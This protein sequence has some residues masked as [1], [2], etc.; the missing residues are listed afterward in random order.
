MD[1]IATW[2]GRLLAAGTVFLLGWG[3]ERAVLFIANR[4][5]RVLR[6]I[7]EGFDLNRHFG[8][9][10]TF[11]LWAFLA[12]SVLPLM[13]LPEP[14]GERASLV[15][16]AAL[17][18]SI[19][20]G[21]V[22][23]I[24][25]GKEVL[26]RRFEIT[27]EDNLAQRRVRTQLQYI[28]RVAAIATVLIG[29]AA[30]LLALPGARQF[31]ASL[32]ASAG[33]AGIVIGFAAQKSLANLVAG[34]QIAF[35][36]PMRI[37]DVL[38]VEGEWGRVEEITLTYVSLK[39][40]DLR[41]LVVPIT[42]F[43]EKPFQNWTRTSAELLGTA[44]FYVDFSVPVGE[45]RKELRRIVERNSLWNK[46]V[47]TLQVTGTSASYV[48]LRAL[49]SADDASRLFDLQCFVR[50]EL[51]GFLNAHYPDS[52]VKTR[53]STPQETSDQEKKGAWTLGPRAG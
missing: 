29:S 10:L 51:I 50:E 41:R 1:W 19:T 32:L 35:T 25:F 2:P 30:V 33:V 11:F 44:E 23:F 8:S 49:V 38:I 7:P 40:W 6:V 14:Y 42:Y 45:V 31:G 37:D 46:K 26:Y 52:F 4:S 13:A 3:L 18:L 5:S 34:F 21:V 28:V 24:Y 17:I 48:L 39:L 43:V 9:A 22:R 16:N 47:C 12:K 15:V 36:Q 53:T 27:A 20:W